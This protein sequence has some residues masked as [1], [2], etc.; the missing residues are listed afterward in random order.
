M[1]CWVLMTVVSDNLMKTTKFVFICRDSSVGRALDWRS[2]GPR[3][4]PGSRQSFLLT[5][6]CCGSAGSISIWI[7]SQELTKKKLFQ[8]EVLYIIN[9]W[10]NKNKMNIYIFLLILTFALHSQV[11][12]LFMLFQLPGSGSG[13]ASSIRWIWIWVTVNVSFTRNVLLVS[14]NC[15]H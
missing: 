8:K 2:K 9:L 5:F 7:R 12:V 15:C 3:F 1:Q 11:T 6:N 4:D 10:N 13:S 14:K